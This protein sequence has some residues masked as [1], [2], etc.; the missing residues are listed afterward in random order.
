MVLKT[1]KDNADLFADSIHIFF[2][3]CVQEGNYSSRLKKTGVTSFF[4]KDAKKSKGNYKPVS[5]LQISSKY[6]EKTV[7]KQ[8]PS[9]LNKIFS[10]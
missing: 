8:I 6:F 5:I 7:F 10:V 9:F 1:V 3:E 2:S 4:K